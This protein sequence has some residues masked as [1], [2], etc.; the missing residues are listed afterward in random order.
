MFCLGMTG[1]GCGR[2]P[3][4]S[5]RGSACRQDDATRLLKRNEDRA[6]PAYEIS[7]EP[8]CRSLVDLADASSDVTGKRNAIGTRP[9]LCLYQIAA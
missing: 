9:C 6:A 4:P 1:P 5:A 7:S 3:R 2:E 8:V